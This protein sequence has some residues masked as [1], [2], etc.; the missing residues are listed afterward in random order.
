MTLNV[1]AGPW[2]FSLP[3]DWQ[4]ASDDPAAPYFENVDGT[5]GCYVKVVQFA[6]SDPPPDL[7]DLAA[8]MQTFHEASLAAV[9]DTAWEVQARAATSSGETAESIVDYLD[10]TRRYRIVSVVQVAPPLGLHL[11]LHHYLC[12]SYAASRAYSTGVL[13]SVRHGDASGAD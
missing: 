8:R 13:A 11:T 6:A 7:A 1:R 2:S 4:G 10:A 3:D 12:E 9:P 5:W